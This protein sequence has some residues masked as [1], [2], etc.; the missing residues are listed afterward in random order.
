MERSDDAAASGGSVLVSRF[1]ALGDVAMTLP[2]LYE[3]CRTFPKRKFVML[4][5]KHPAS[6]F[7]NAPDNLVVKGI[8]TDLYRGPAGLWRLSGELQHEFKFDTYVDL[9]DV[10]RTRLLRLFMR[11]RGVKHIR[12]IVKGRSDK[13]ALTRR[14][15]KVL[16]PLPA[17]LLRY[18]DT[19]RRAG[20][21]LSGSGEEAFSTVFKRRRPDP[22]IF[23]EASDPKAPGEVWIAIAPFA[24]HQGKIY[25]SDLLKQVVDRYAP[26][27]FHRIFL[28]GAG[29]KE[30]AQLDMLRDGRPNIVNLARVKLG[31]PAELSLLSFCDVMLSM[32]S[33][34]MHLASLVGLPVVSVWGATHPY[35]GFMGWKQSDRDA[36]QLDMVCRPCSV[37]GNKSCHRGDYHCL[38]GISPQR[39]IDRLDSRLKERTGDGPEE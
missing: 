5:R 23:L 22:S 37:F 8:D 25:P 35:A 3:A 14:H 38:R 6:V 36:V 28:F 4:T 13:R 18:A 19:F 32:D 24:R 29:E 31:I 1:S 7:V 17:T 16:L 15:N 33:A 27:P 9:H 34:N 39:I 21:P 30:A 12:H 20:M 26:L 2:S 10:V 11:L